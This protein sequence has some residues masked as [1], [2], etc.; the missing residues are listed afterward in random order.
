MAISTI[1]GRSQ[2]YNTSMLSYPFVVCVTYTDLYLTQMM[3]EY[4]KVTS[5]KLIIYIN[6]PRWQINKSEQTDS[7]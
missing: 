5:G 6:L 7:A 3:L 2:N 1:N 4:D